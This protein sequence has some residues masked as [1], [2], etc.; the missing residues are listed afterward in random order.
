MSCF[1]SEKGFF[2]KLEEKAF[3]RPTTWGL[4][5]ISSLNFFNNGMISVKCVEKSLRSKT[6]D[7][8]GLGR[9]C[10]AKLRPVSLFL[11]IKSSVILIQKF[12]QSIQ[13]SYIPCHSFQYF[14][15]SFVLI[16]SF[17]HFSDCCLQNKP[18]H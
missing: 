14:I 3:Q 9:I 17:L 5:L 4:F 15:K 2:L 8:G 16:L 11:R 6:S 1:C 13:K 18:W 12:S 10:T 7:P